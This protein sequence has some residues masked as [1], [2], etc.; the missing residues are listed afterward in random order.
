MNQGRG[1]EHDQRDDGTRAHLDKE[2]GERDGD[3]LENRQVDKH[4][5][6]AIL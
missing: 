3:G 5:G 4:K 1:R 6:L 2:V